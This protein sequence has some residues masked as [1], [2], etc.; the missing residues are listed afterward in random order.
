MPKRSLP[1]AM[2]A[3]VAGIVVLCCVEADVPRLLTDHLTGT[4]WY[5]EQ[6]EEGL[7]HLDALPRIEAPLP[8]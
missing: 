6:L 8:H 1:P 7:G 5:E 3:L 4:A 2:Y